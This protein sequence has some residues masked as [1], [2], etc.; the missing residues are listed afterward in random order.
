MIEMLKMGLVI[1][2]TPTMILMLTVATATGVLFGALPG[3]SAAMG[4]TL[5]LPFSYSMGNAEGV[6]F[7]VAVY[8]AAITG[9]GITAILF[10]IPGTPA[11][12]PTVFDGYPMAQKGQTGKALATSLISSAIGGI[13]SAIVMFFL[14]KQ[15]SDIALHFGTAELFAVA[16]LG[17]SILTS[18]DSEKPLKT[19][20]SGIMGLII[21]TIGID[22]VTGVKRLTFGV[23]S[24]LSGIPMISVMIG[25]F[26]LTEVIVRIVSPIEMQSSSNDG[27][28]SNTFLSVKEALT[29]KWIWLRQ[30]VMGTLIGILP[31]AGASIAAFLGYVAEV[32]LSK[33]PEKF[34][35][36]CLEGI[37]AP[38]TANNAATGGAMI[39]LLSLGIP[40]G[41]TAAIIASAMTMK[42]MQLGPLLMSKQPDLLSV[43]FLSMIFVN[44]VMVF[45]A[46]GIAKIFSK[47]INLPYCGLG[48]FIIMLCMTGSFAIQN[49]VANMTIMVIAGAIG[50][51]FIQMGFSPSAFILGLVLGP[52]CETN[53]R[54][55]VLIAHGNYA[56]VF[57]RPL[58][59]IIVSVCVIVNII[60]LVW[61]K[62]KAMQLK[63][64]S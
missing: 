19:F 4:V 25:M 20:M 38:E 35:T 37:A 24:L 63:K 6:A 31:G 47:I 33:E 16:L 9:G 13:F 23:T 60:P 41:N 57:T 43:T 12:A 14:S 2:C 34:G 26:A 17:L 3:V 22:S 44:I 49:N 50:I 32:K 30:S 28:V 51:I 53:L 39:P 58:T 46:I 1:I 42:G 54:R 18:L 62:I 48:S 59:L 52:I 10:R 29:L 11:S 64:N 61:P 36:G 55:A 5:M 27:N 21:A 7:L 15:L 40:G 56:K 8:C 45:I